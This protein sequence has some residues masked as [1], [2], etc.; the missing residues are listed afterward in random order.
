MPEFM[1]PLVESTINNHVN[2]DN[3][4]NLRQY[5]GPI[6]IVRRVDDEIIADPPGV[7]A[8]NR[9]NNLIVEYVIKRYGKP[10]PQSAK[11][12]LVDWVNMPHDRDVPAM[13][14]LSGDTLDGVLKGAQDP[15][16][17]LVAMVK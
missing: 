3:L 12:Q 7:L 8:C 5:K 17:E 6:R 13:D 11:D 10:V 4:D 14:C 2:L 15:S 9:G 1:S 16:R